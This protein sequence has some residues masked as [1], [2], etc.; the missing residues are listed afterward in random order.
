[1]FTGS[2]LPS[3]ITFQA[4]NSVDS[5]L[6]ERTPSSTRPPGE[7]AYLQSAQA[8]HGKSGVTVR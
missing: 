5:T 7:D 8:H 2:K 1:M 3:V 4:K 6:S